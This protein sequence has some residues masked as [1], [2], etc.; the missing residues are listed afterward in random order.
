MTLEEARR[1]LQSGEQQQAEGQFGQA[2]QTFLRLADHFN[3]FGGAAVLA[4]A[5]RSLAKISRKRGQMKQ[6]LARIERALEFDKVQSNDAGMM[7]DYEFLGGLYLSAGLLDSA[8]NALCKALELGSASHQ[9]AVI[10]VAYG[11]LGLIS[12]RR[13]NLH[14]A[15]RLFFKSLRMAQKLERED[16]VS[17]QRANLASIYAARGQ[18]AR[19]CILLQ[20][21]LRGFRKLGMEHAVAH[22]VRALQ[23]LNGQ[24]SS[25]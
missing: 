23:L 19:A 9:S 11:N 17:T 18:T 21:A 4:Q 10:T 7:A 8:E 1:H 5:H 24:L 2:E 15:Q 14:H 13:G 20:N 25:L 6:A 22:S 12:K 3:D 16:I